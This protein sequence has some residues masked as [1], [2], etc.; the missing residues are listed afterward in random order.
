MLVLADSSMGMTKK[1][2]ELRLSAREEVEW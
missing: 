2:E 1:A